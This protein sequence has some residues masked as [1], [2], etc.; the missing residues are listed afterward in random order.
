M[1]TTTTQ[2]NKVTFYEIVGSDGARVRLAPESLQNVHSELGE[3]LNKTL[4]SPL[5]TMK[6]GRKQ[7]RKQKRGTSG[8]NISEDKKA[9]VL[10]SVLKVLDV[11]EGK[12]LN[13]IIIEIKNRF[14]TKVYPNQAAA[15]RAFLEQRPEIISE[16]VQSR[17]HYK[18]NPN[19]VKKPEPAAK[20][21]PAAASA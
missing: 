8:V 1:S 5:E 14:K 18:L 3:I 13:A 17:T 11:K 15:V 20:T 9:E 12:T 2:I 21:V 10:K 16:E 19:Q 7:K 6:A 4:G